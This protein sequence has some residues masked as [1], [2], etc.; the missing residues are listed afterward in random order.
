MNYNPYF[1]GGQ[2]AMRAPLVDGQVTY[3]DGTAATIPQMATDVATFLMWTAEP[4]LEERK[5][6]GFKVMVFL[7]VFAL[8][9][10]FVYRRV[11]R[12]VEH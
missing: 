1:P 4:K 10:F 3:A 8:L 7:G 2:I 5:E 11:W 9:L 6:L 12:D